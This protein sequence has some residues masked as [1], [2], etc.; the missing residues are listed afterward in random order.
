MSLKKDKFNSLDKKYMRFAINL[1]SNNNGLTGTNPSVG[2][3]VVKNKEIISYGSTKINGRP[4]AEII[5]LRK[6]KKKIFGS[7]LYVTLEPCSHFGKT[8][9]CTKSIIKSKVKKVNYSIEDLDYR[10]F[11][12]SKKI[13]KSN[14]I[15][16]KSGLLKNETKVIYKKYNY[17]KKNNYPYITGKLACSSN[18]YILKNNSL[19]TNV[20]SRSVSHLLRYRNHGI[21]TSYKTINSDNPKLNCRISGLEK[22][23]PKRIILDKNLKIKMNTYIMMSSKKIKTLIFHNS[24]NKKKIKKI[25]NKGIK[26]I[27]LDVKNNGDFNLKE[28]IKIIYNNGIH[29]LLVEF[30]KDLT[31]KMISEK[32]FN[33]FYLFRSGKNLYNKEKINVSN[34]NK[35]LIKNFKTF[36]YVNTYL[37]KDKLIHYY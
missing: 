25:K 36:K 20:H 31:Q 2:C 17:I 23:S 35:Q 21:L 24:K 4:H 5:A 34:I 14:K 3:V 7:L 29:N 9:P 32:L 1:A 28:V 26:L 37:D 12:K 15:I 11:N 27:Y 16:T 33:E 10:T 6:N 18:F 30:G 19:I 8:P 13:L 22:F